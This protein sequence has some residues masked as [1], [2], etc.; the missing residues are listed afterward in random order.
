MAMIN[1]YSE[2]LLLFNLFIPIAPGQPLG[3]C[4]HNNL[5]NSNP[6]LCVYRPQAAVELR[7]VL[8]CGGP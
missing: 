7:F 5:S 4:G 6:A 1:R 2:N 8:V 3:I